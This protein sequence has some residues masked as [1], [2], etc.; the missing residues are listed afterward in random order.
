M[1]DR[2]DM[3]A[4]VRMLEFG[5]VKLHETNGISVVGTFKLEQ[6]EEAFDSAKKNSMLGQMVVFAP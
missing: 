1:Y 2:D 4:M 3:I 6:W 5:S